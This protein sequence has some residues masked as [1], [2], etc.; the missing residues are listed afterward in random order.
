M[1]SPKSPAE[2]PSPK[3]MDPDTAKSKSESTLYHGDRSPEQDLTSG[4]FYNKSYP[5]LEHEADDHKLRQYE[6][7]RSPKRHV[8]KYI[9]KRKHIPSSVSRRS[10]ILS[11]AIQFQL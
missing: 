10:Y 4:S 9:K 2:P 8:W 5:S 7:S 3:K 6:N 11:K 1:R